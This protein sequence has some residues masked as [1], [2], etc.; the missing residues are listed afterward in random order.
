MLCSYISESSASTIYDT[1]HSDTA[2]RPTISQ[3][4]LGVCIDG[5][6]QQPWE[7][8]QFCYP[9]ITGEEKR[10]TNSSSDSCMVQAR[11]RSQEEIYFDLGRVCLQVITIHVAPA[12]AWG[13][14]LHVF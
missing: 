5:S 12:Y 7:R 3:G 11:N 13:A 9:K 1:M 2:S 10:S 4:D 6:P 14:W 8:G